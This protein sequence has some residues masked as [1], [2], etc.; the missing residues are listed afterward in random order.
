MRR[1][2]IVSRPAATGGNDVPLLAMADDSEEASL[3]E[4]VYDQVRH[5]LITGRILPGVAISTRGLA[6]QLGVSQTP[7]RDAL[8]RIS[9]EG[10]VRIES[11]RAIIVPRM[12]PERYEEIMRCRLLLEPAAAVDALPHIDA[13]RLRSIREADRALDRAVEEGDVNGYLQSNFRFHALIYQAAPTTILNRMIESLWMQ[14]GPFMRVV[15]GRF[16]TA[17]L[18]DHHRA[19]CEAIAAGDSGAL[20]EAIRGDIGDGMALMRDWDQVVR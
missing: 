20:A 4:R 10:A 14:F 8:S 12:T 16:G 9:A 11:K 3:R 18:I 15:Y 7:V 17:N 19:A 6:Q 13:G 2:G 5:S 1:I